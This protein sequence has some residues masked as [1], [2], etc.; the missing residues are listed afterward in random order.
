MTLRAGAGDP[1][2]PLLVQGELPIA[3]VLP[4]LKARGLELV[5]TRNFAFGQTRIVLLLGRQAT[6]ENWA[7]ALG[8]LVTSDGLTQRF[9]FLYVNARVGMWG[10][11]APNEEVRDWADG[12]RHDLRE[13]LAGHGLASTEPSGGAGDW[14]SP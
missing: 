9:D 13:K 12:V 5:L 6:P 1:M 11:P 8:L 4:I 10:K 14:S 2:D 3:E 7:T